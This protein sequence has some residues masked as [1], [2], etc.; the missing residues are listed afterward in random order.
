MAV[1]RYLSLGNVI[2]A[3]DKV[4][5][6][7]FSAARLTYQSRMGACLYFQVKPRNNGGVA[8][9][10]MKSHILECNIALYVCK[11]QC[12]FLVG[13]VRLNV[14]DLEKSV[15]ARHTS[16]ELFS[17]LHYPADRGKKCGSVQQICRKV[18]GGYLT[19]HH[20]IAAQRHDDDVHYSVKGTGGAVESA[21]IFVALLFDV[22]ELAVVLFKLFD[23]GVLTSEGLYHTYSQQTVLGACVYLAQLRPL[24]AE[25]LSHAAVELDGNDYHH[26][27]CRKHYQR[28]GDVHGAEYGK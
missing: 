12:I 18:G 6:R 1:N 19:L 10:I 13:N 15:N 21:H 2:K 23:L 3:G 8:V 28:Q 27:H 5:E 16:L 22:K 26:G 7:C 9:G 17:E 11:L 20:K 4:A 14:H 25:H 24:R